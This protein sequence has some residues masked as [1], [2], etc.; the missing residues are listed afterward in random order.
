LS[1]VSLLSPSAP[2]SVRSTSQF[3]A[4]FTPA[5]VNGNPSNTPYL[6]TSRSFVAATSL[7]DAGTRATS[8][9]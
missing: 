9:P 8:G 3:K 4:L 5:T 6:T 1:A 2:P 7:F